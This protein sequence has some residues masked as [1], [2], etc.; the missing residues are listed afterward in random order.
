MHIAFLTNPASGQINVQFA[1]AQHLVSDGCRVT[2]LSEDSCRG[3]VAQFRDS[4]SAD[5]RALVHF[6]GFGSAQIILD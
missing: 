4:Q 5:R 3:K 1:I 6:I 2:F